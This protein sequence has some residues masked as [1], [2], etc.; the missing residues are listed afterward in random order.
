MKCAAGKGVG[1]PAV[2]AAFAI[3][4][5]S[6]SIGVAGGY[7]ISRREAHAARRRETRLAYSALLGAI[8]QAVA[9]FR[10]MPPARDTPWIDAALRHIQ[11]A[12]GQWV[13]NQRQVLEV[14]GTFPQELGMV[15]AQ[16]YNHLRILDAPT[17]LPAL[18]DEA[19]A[20]VDAL[21][22]QR[23]PELVDRWPDL[24]ERLLATGRAD[25]G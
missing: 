18:V 23:S 6:G 15:I 13:A 7:W 10:G 20:Y 4:L 25:L 3:A 1:S 17:S 2:L 9:T 12:E 16:H 8:S 11:S 19:M 21:T 24:H 14:F 5:V 22:V